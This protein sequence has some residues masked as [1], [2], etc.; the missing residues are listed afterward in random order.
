M[1]DVEGRPFRS[2]SENVDSAIYCRERNRG[3]ENEKSIVE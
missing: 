1:E 2:D 3:D